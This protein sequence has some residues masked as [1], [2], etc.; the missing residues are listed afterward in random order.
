MLQKVNRHLFAEAGK[1]IQTITLM[2]WRADEG[3]SLVVSPASVVMNWFRE[4]AR[5]APKLRTQVLNSAS[6]RAELLA[7]LGPGDVVLCSYGVLV[8]EEEALT[9]IQWNVACLDEAH[10]IKN[11]DTKSFAAAV[12]LRAA[13][14]VALTGTPVQNRLAEL[15]SLMQFL[16][17]GLL[18]TFEQFSSK[19][20]VPIESLHDQK[21]RSQLKAILAPFMLRRTKAEV[22]DELPDKTEIVRTVQLSD[23]ELRAY[24]TY[25]ISVKEHLDEESK[26]GVNALAQI[27]FLREAA[28]DMRLVN[29]EWDGPSSKLSDMTG[30]LSE[31]VSGGNKVL[32]FSQFTSYLAYA[33]K[34]LDANGIEY[35]YL[36]G[37][38][39]VRRRIALV[40]EF[41][42][43]GGAQVF[44]ISLKA[45]GLGLNLTKASYVLHLDPWWNPSVEQQATDRVYRIGQRQN[46]TVYHLVSG[47]TI[48]EKIL[49]LHRTKRDLADSILE[50]T[51]TSHAISLEELRELV[52]EE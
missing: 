30:L 49:R 32:V 14:R 50:G 25:R 52:S 19:F 42:K 35:L 13:M 27:S 1:T 28:C 46:V 38:T 48:E 4:L 20:I 11:R 41:Q 47:H 31:I 29:P 9:A 21:R 16:N 12:R 5:F 40:D 17:P 6:S 43:S 2:L 22:V 36:D 15:W 45:G 33:K 8:S 10:L 7:S 39:S 24:E 51:S 44:L 37:S 34:A 26:V 18:G 23:D 3:P